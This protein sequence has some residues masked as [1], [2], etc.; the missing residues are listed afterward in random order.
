MNDL[1][2]KAG[3]T[4]LKRALL[5]GVIGAVLT[6]FI[7][8]QAVTSTNLG[9]GSVKLATESFSDDADVSVVGKGIMVVASNAS[10]LGGS[11]PGVEMDNTLPAVRTALTKNN[12][13]YEFEVKEAAV[14]S[15]QSGEN[16][17]IEVYG[18]DGTTTTLLATLYTQ[19]GTVD[20]VNVEGVT[21]TVDLASTSIVHDNFDIIVTRQ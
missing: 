21:V 6:G 16:L 9:N 8:A 3:S 20:D 12:Y 10:A 14:T 15:F 18:D 2:A 4:A 5:L 17:K 13:A 1:I 19:Q 7:A 11:A